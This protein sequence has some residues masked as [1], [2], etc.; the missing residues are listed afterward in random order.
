MVLVVVGVQQCRFLTTLILS[1]SFTLEPL[2]CLS[3]YIW[4]TYDHIQLQCV[5]SSPSLSDNTNIV[6]SAA[7]AADHGHGPPH[8]DH[9]ADRECIHSF[10]TIDIFTYHLRGRLQGLFSKVD[11]ICLYFCK[12]YLSSL[13]CTSIILNVEFAWA[14]ES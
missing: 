14:C 6:F 8:D 4:K 2:A 1:K 10:A 3:P 9:A 5:L 13:Y 12:K 7:G 11:C